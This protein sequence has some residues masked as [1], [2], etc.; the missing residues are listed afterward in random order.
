MATRGRSP[1]LPSIP[2]GTIANPFDEL[3]RAG[4]DGVAT[5]PC[6]K[7]AMEFFVATTWHWRHL[8]DCGETRNSVLRYRMERRG[9]N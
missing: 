2:R 7:K 8:R 9:I 1:A 4:Y 3:I 6:K 5:N